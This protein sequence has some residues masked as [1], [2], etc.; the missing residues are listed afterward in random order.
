[1]EADRSG[2]STTPG[3]QPDLTRPALADWLAANVAGFTPPFTA[4]RFKGGQS[5]PTY[6]LRA[7]SGDYVLRSKPV[8]ALLRGA[9]AVER[10]YAIIAAL[11]PTG[12]PVARPHALCEDSA[13]V[14]APFYVMDHVAGRIFWDGSLPDVARD[15]RAPHFDAMN[16]TLA[17]LHVVEPAAIGLGDYGR[18]DNYLARQIARW[19]RQYLDD[20]AAGR[21][22]AMDR[23]VAWLPANIPAGDAAAIVHGDFRCDNMIFDA[24]RPSVIAVLDWELSTLGHPLADFA[25]HALMYRVPP[26]LPWGLAGR[27]L[28]AL[29]L[30]S[31]AD[32]V[33]A[34]CARTGRDGIADL[35]FYFAFNLFRFAAIIHGVIGRVLRGTAA[36]AR[37]REAAASFAPVAA[38][39]WAQAERAMAG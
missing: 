28:A 38:L 37:A 8:G 12:F 34:Y 9:H 2:A 23:L 27:D 32:Y 22:A 14:G 29:G 26:T 39:G 33:A 19:S 10:E 5:N 7:A 16:A 11:H 15:A 30:P 18:P 24:H 1:M 4:E 3:A 17:A 20:E 21:D 25:Y 36:S 35:D 31:E 6:R 13:V